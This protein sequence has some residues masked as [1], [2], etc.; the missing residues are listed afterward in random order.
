MNAYLSLTRLQRTRRPP[1]RYYA[2]P[3]PDE[4][5][6]LIYAN[7]LMLRTGIAE[8]L[9]PVPQAFVGNA[10]S[11][12]HITDTVAAIYNLTDCFNLKF[13]W[14]TFTMSEFSPSETN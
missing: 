9:N 3:S 4:A 11:L 13:F 6:P 1:L 12:G 14:V 10:K 7:R 8:E 5:Q 2:P